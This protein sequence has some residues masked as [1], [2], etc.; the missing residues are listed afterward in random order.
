MVVGLLFMYSFLIGKPTEFI[1]IFL[2]YMIT[3]GYYTSAFHAHSMRNCLLLSIIIFAF[4][5]TIALPKDISI[6]ASGG[7]GILIAY[8]GA[9]AGGLQKQIAE[10]KEMKA[11]EQ[12]RA[13]GFDCTTCSEE[14]LIARCNELH[15]SEAKIYMAKEFFIKKTKHKIIAE[16]YSIE[17]QS[18][19]MSKW[20]M[21]KELEQ[22]DCDSSNNKRTNL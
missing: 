5:T 8:I 1:L 21:K 2:P 15:Y 14:E 10:Y 6:I 9:K 13:A 12:S 4:A 20:R 17:P 18:V 3:K 19:T 7:L 22:T 11:K 16:K